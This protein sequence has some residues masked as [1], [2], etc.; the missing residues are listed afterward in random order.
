MTVF[1]RQ[2]ELL[3]SLRS[4]EGRSLKELGDSLGVSKSTIQRDLDQLSCAGVPITD[5][6]RGQRLLYRLDAAAPQAAHALPLSAA[7]L[8]PLLTALR[9]WRRT[10]WFKA[11]KSRLGPLDASGRSLDASAPEPL[12]SGGAAALSHLVRGLLE[13][14]KVRVSYVPRERSTPWR[15]TI[16]P[17]R[18][19]T[20]G[21]LLYLDAHVAGA[22]R[23]FAVHRVKEA[24]VSRSAFT[25]C[26]LP[27][28]T[29]FGAVESAPVE[30]VVKF[31]A[32]VAEFIRERRWHPSEQVEVRPDGTLLWRGTVSG[33]HEF[34]GWVMSWSPWA[35]LVSPASWR[36]S[37]LDRARALLRS[38]Q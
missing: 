9:P 36:R 20:A 32:P 18:L 16:E 23:T 3:R 7:E 15:V 4:S 12:V 37:L 19:R 13:H 30:V 21:G 1:A 17:A 24:R 35:E 25:P 28:R 10:S 11:L 8:A 5:E 27:E 31:G 29:A 33:E 6:Q 2:P 26:A 14:R 22:F 34:I 38:H